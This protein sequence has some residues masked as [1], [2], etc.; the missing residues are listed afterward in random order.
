MA[1]AMRV[2]GDKEGNGNGNLG[3]R[4][5]TAIVTKRVMVTATRVAGK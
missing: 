1:L 2:V 5:A 3:G 4:R